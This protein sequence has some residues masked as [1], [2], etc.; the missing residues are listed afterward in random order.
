[1][2]I[3]SY[4]VICKISLDSTKGFQL[5]TNI[6]EA[7]VVLSLFLAFLGLIIIQFHVLDNNSVAKKERTLILWLLITLFV[8]VISRVL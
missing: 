7:S 8:F 6:R 4:G 1:M 5:P 2:Q 3:L